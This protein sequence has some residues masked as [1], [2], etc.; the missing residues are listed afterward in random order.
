MQALRLL[1][2]RPELSQR[3]LS[4]EIGL[5]LGK[6]HY[7]LHAL[8]DKGFV[9][10]QN[11]RRSDNKLSYAYLLTPKGMKEKVRLTRAFLAHKEAE[12]E[13]LRITI[14]LLQ[15]EVQQLSPS[16]TDPGTSP[17]QGSARRRTHL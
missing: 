15:N 6:T 7:L 9:K 5:S 8:L 16:E 17:S 14:A 1:A 3:E 11:F 13:R 10:I 4:R 2:M 12:F